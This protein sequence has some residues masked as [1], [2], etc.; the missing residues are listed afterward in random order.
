MNGDLSGF[1]A[2]VVNQLAEPMGPARVE[3]GRINGLKFAL[4][5]TD[6]GMNGKVTFLYD[7][8]KVA[9]LNMDEETKE[10]SKKKLLSIVANVMLKNSNP[11]KRDK[12]PR[13]FDVENE[14]DPNRSIFHLAWK[15]LFIGVKRTV[16][17][18]K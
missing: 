5:G 2:K 14:R 17:I 1:D 6:Y 12:E 9:L 11:S 8:L 13:S 18:K 16:G 3:D 4:Q 15:T 10:L 7:D